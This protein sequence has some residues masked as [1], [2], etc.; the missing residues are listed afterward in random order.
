MHEYP[1]GELLKLVWSAVNMK[2]K[3][4]YNPS[5]GMDDQRGM[6]CK[7]GNPIQTA[8]MRGLY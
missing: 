3:Y 2:L 8:V 1:R 6:Y 4:N 7:K 5:T